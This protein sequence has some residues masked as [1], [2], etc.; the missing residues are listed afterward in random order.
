V[1]R[2]LTVLGVVTLSSCSVSFDEATTGVAVGP[3]ITGSDGRIEQF[4]ISTAEGRERLSHSTAVLMLNDVLA[5]IELAPSW[6]LRNNICPDQRFWDQP[7]ASFCTAV[8]VDWD[9]VL[10]AGHCVRYA[11]L[12]ELSIVFGYY[13]VAPGE[14]ARRAIYSPQSIVA[15]ALDLPTSAQRLDFAWLQLDRRVEFPL[16][17]SP[18]FH[19]QMP[20]LSGEPLVTIGAP[21][22]MPLK[23]D[24]TGTLENGGHAAGFFTATTDTSHGWSGGGAYDED[25][26]LLGIL[27]RGADDLVPA[28][29]GCL[30]ETQVEQAAPPQEEFTYAYLALE[31]LC[32]RDGSRAICG[33]CDSTCKAPAPAKLPTFDSNQT[34]CSVSAA[35]LRTET[36]L[37]ESLYLAIIFAMGIARLKVSYSRGS[38]PT[39]SAS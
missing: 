17:P 35:G 24:A 14:L 33:N 22:G 30:R 1:S 12:S 10:T 2:A 28:D 20:H 3:V 15:E 13:Y 39:S 27:S 6:G 29:G 25:L 21:H 7:T 38:S 32:A 4:E 19:Q 9:L 34:A 36:K 31:A 5:S 37:I 23:F 26:T 11:P 16:E 18:F 8:L